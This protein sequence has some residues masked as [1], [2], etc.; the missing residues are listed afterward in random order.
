[1]RHSA[2]CAHCTTCHHQCHHQCMP[3]PAL[4]HPCTAGF[5][6]RDAIALLR[7]DDLYVECFEVKDVKTLRGEHLSRCIGRLAGKVSWAAG[8][9]A[10]T[11]AW[12]AS[13]TAWEVYMLRSAVA[14]AAE[15]QHAPACC[16]CALLQGEATPLCF[17]AE[18]DACIQQ[19]WQVCQL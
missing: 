7:L 10:A 12:A 19:V 9:Q 11:G 18:V 5:E 13:R 6:I 4:L 8:D 17:A 3:R 2:S 14:G 1:M 15:G 16:H